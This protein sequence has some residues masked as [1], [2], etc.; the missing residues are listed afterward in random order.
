MPPLLDRLAEA[1]ETATRPADGR[2]ATL[3]TR[4]AMADRVH[5]NLQAFFASGHLVSPAWKP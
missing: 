5:D 4:Q 3:E 2:A 1:C